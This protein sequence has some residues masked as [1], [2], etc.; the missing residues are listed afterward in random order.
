MA[1]IESN[2]FNGADLNALRSIKVPHT[3]RTEFRLNNIDLLSLRN[4][5]I[6]A[7]WFA[8]IAV[9]TLIGNQQGHGLLLA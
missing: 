1:G 4:S 3:F 6:R 9:N 2:A 5:P 7:L 8:N